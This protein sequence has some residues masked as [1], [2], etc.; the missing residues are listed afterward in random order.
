MYFNPVTHKSITD[1]DWWQLSECDNS[2]FKG[3]VMFTSTELATMDILGDPLVSVDSCSLSDN[4]NR[5]RVRLLHEQSCIEVYAYSTY[6]SYT[7]QWTWLYSQLHC[8]DFDKKT[9]TLTVQLYI[10]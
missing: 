7:I 2:E 1:D 10:R 8:I 3:A 4:I 9:L 6:S 5:C